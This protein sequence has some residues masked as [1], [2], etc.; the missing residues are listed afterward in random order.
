[1]ITL[2]FHQSYNP[3][4]DLFFIY[5]FVTSVLFF[6]TIDFTTEN[7]D[8]QYLIEICFGVVIIYTII[9]LIFRPYPDRL[10]QGSIILCEIVKMLFLV[11]LFLIQKSILS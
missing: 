5:L 7:Q 6:F 1:M 8:F 2:K 9:I 3:Y 4:T 11:F 10:N